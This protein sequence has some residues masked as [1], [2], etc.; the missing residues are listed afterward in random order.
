MDS[1]GRSPFSLKE[2]A[3]H[4]RIPNHRSDTPYDTMYMATPE[5]DYLRFVVGTADIFETA[6]RWDEFKIESVPGQ[7]TGQRVTTT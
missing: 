6:D 7:P 5:V 4:P 3:C 1:Q 2:A